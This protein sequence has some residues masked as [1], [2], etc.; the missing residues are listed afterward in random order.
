MKKII[1][2]FLC[3]WSALLQSCNK[4]DV[5]SSSSFQN[6]GSIN[7]SIAGKIIDESG[8]SIA[9]AIVQIGSRSYSTDAN[10]LFYLTGLTLNNE[11]AVIKVTKGGY[12][13]RTAALF[14]T[15]GHTG[16]TKVVMP[17]KNFN[18]TV[19]GTAGGTIQS[20]NSIISFP[21]NAFT[22][23]SGAAYSGQVHIAFK[24]LPTTNPNF[25]GLIPG[26][27]LLEIGRAHV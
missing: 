9:G 21:A 13:D 20:G 2:L 22:T 14:V 17:L 11:R 4:D 12:W 24:D 19:S 8:A 1:L 23:E 15:S 7:C 3:V 5:D 18:N 26:T 6:G 25:G 27:D 10:G 16:F